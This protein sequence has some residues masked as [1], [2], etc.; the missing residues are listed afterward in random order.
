MGPMVL[1]PMLQRTF[2]ADEDEVE[3][4]RDVEGADGAEPEVRRNVRGVEE[5]LR[6][7]QRTLH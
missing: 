7:R 1:S 6:P 5:P 3:G 2:E 4:D